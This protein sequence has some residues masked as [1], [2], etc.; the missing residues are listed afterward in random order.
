MIE[1]EP[2]FYERVDVKMKLDNI[3]GLL[4]YLSGNNVEADCAK[5]QRTPTFCEHVSIIEDETFGHAVSCEDIQRLAWKAPGNIYSERGTLSFFWRSRYP[6][7]PTEFPIFRVGFADHSSWD[8]CWLRIDYNGDGFDAMITDSNLSRA[9]V[10]VT[11]D[12]FPNKDDWIHLA[13]TWDENYGIC[14]YINGQLAAQEHRPAVYFTGLDQFGPHSR[15]I[16]NW[17]VTS[18]YNF[19]RGGDLARISIYDRMLDE[20]AISTLFTGSLYDC[21][22]NYSIDFSDSDVKE[23]WLNR[24]GL[25]Q[26][27]PEITP[28]SSIRKVEIHDAYDLKRWYWKACDGIRETTWPGVYNRS[29][30]KGRNDYFQLPDWDCYS[31]SGKSIIFTP[32]KEPYNHIEITGSAHGCL[33]LLDTEGNVRDVLFNRPVGIERTVHKIPT[34][35]SSSLRFTN[36]EIEEPIG[37]F[38]LLYVKEGKSPIG[39]KS[40]TYHIQSGYREFENVQNE[41]ISFIHGRYTLDERNIFTAIKNQDIDEA[42]KPFIDTLHRGYPFFHII[43]PYEEDDDFGL[44]GIELIIDKDAIDEDVICNIQIKDPLWYYRNL[45]QFTCKLQ[46][47]QGYNLWCD[48]R[49]RILPEDRCLYITLAFDKWVDIGRLESG[50]KIRTIYK[51]AREAKAEHVADRFIQVRDVFGHLMEERPAQKEFN[52]Y[53][54][55]RRDIEDLMRIDPKHIPGQY[56]RYELGVLHRTKAGILDNYLPDYKTEVVPEGVPAWAFKQ[57]E[58]LKHYKYVINWY[59]DERQIENGEFG[60]G[61]SDD[62]D[63]TS[64]FVGLVHM[65]CNPNKVLDSLI[66]CTEAFYEQ[67]MFTNGLCS[68]QTDELHSSEE[69]VISLNQCLN[70]DFANPIFLE[71]AMENARSAFWLTGINKAGHRHFKSTYFSGS[72]MA[73]EHPWGGQQSL[74]NITLTPSWY[75][76]RYNGNKKLRQLVTEMAD[77]LAAHYDPETG[78]VNSYVR[79]EDDKEFSPHNLR[80]RG[81]MYTL[82]PAYRATGNRRYLELIKENFRKIPNSY[83]KYMNEYDK[84]SAEWVDKEMVAAQYEERCFIAGIRKYYNTEGYPWIDRVLINYNDIQYDR[85]GGVAY[86]RQLC[87]YPKNRIS[88]RFS[89]DNDDEKIAVLS[90]IA[91]DNQIK[92]IICN[93]SNEDIDTIIKGCEVN[94][95]KWRLKFGTDSDDDDTINHILREEILPFERSSEIGI[96]VPA[97]STCILEMEIVEDGTPYWERC[98]LGLSREDI[99]FYP[100]GINIRIHS[101]GA[102]HSPEAEIVLKDREGKIRRT[103]VLPPLEAPSDL[104]P[105]YR[106]VVFNTWDLS[107]L[108]GFTIEIDPFHRLNE[109]TRDNN[110]ITL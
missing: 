25:Y 12:P 79:F 68:I 51:E 49:D 78:I 58:F 24:Y 103:A 21:E 20:K 99:R 29:R 50:L 100:H 18:D 8:A 89:R 46:K 37:D 108:T 42:I 95:G 91:L 87:V 70:A 59:I 57:I 63:F 19:I 4:F 84:E 65:G 90:P 97:K 73:L 38:T 105:R 107:D 27:V 10:S 43:I 62:G 71:R 101:L 22:T 110:I 88:W 23:G 40:E 77:G 35:Q 55:F 48:T 31:I 74:S 86:E 7:G 76:L 82:Y 61:L 41:L 67:G 36:D 94:P 85:L 17:N 2:L 53:N 69:G 106:D 92:L 80:T 52:L 83:V 3:K 75:L 9:R 102:V 34:Q 47:N 60:G 93:I 44:D 5:G 26:S 39:K 33:E 66:R 56:Y 30:L 54:R 64:I 16:S 11:M 6:V 14:F 28:D 32:L 98:D 45:M 13:L 15:S 72:H 104:W 109:I 1:S 96:T 81:E